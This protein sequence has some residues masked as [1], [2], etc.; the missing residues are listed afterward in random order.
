MKL[1]DKEILTA[2]EVA[3]L[4]QISKVTLWKLRKYRGLPSFKVGREVRFFKHE[5][6][7]WIQDERYREAQL[8]L[9]FS[10]PSGSREKT[11]V[12]TQPRAGTKGNLQRKLTRS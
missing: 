10:S 9:E 12:I 2:D 3:E 7:R 1:L 8:G 11:E 6:L 4:L 5:L